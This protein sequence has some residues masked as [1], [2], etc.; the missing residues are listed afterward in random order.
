MRIINTNSMKEVVEVLLFILMVIL[1]SLGISIVGIIGMS[2]FLIVN[3]MYVT[4]LWGILS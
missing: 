3:A 1:G 2:T 4:N